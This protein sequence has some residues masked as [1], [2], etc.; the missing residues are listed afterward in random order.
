MRK[1]KK[2]I[3]IATITCVGLPFVLFIPGVRWSE[4]MG[5][6]P[7]GGPQYVAQVGDVPISAQDFLERYNDYLDARARAGGG[8][9]PSPQELM[10]DGTVERL[11]QQMV[12][13]ALLRRKMGE[14]GYDA[15]Q[16]YLAELL[17]KEV[18]FLD[19]NGQLDAMYYNQWVQSAQGIDWN[20]VYDQMRNKMNHRMVIKLTSASA[21]ALD[22]DVRRQYVDA[23][24]KIVVKHAAI[25][26]KV[27]LTE[28]EI[29]EFWE[30]SKESYLTD[31]E[32]T[33]EFVAFSLEAP[34]PPVVEDILMRAGAGEDFAELAKTF[35]Q[36]PDKSQVGDMRW[37]VDGENTPAHRKALFD[38]EAGAISDPVKGP[39]GIH[40]YK[41]E[42]KRDNE[43]VEG[44]QDVCVR[45]IVIRLALDA[46]ER[47]ARMANAKK[48]LELAQGDGGLAGAAEEKGL[49]V[50]TTDS[51][52]VGS[53][54]IK[55]VFAQDA[56]TFRQ[57]LAKVEL[58]ALSGVVE[59]SEFLY[60]A[61]VVGYIEPQQKA[62]EDVRDD[63]ERDAIALRKNGEEYLGALQQYFVDIQSKADNLEEANR[64]FPELE[65][66][67]KQ[68]KAF[69][70][71]DY[72]FTDGIFWNCQDAFNAVGRSQPGTMGG[73]IRDFSNVYHFVE[74]VEAILPTE[75]EGAK[76]WE[77]EKETL[78]ERELATLQFER[79]ADY[80][81]YMREQA[82]SEFLIQKNWE[83]ISALL[84]PEQPTE[85]VDEPVAGLIEEAAEEP[86]EAPTE[87][88]VEESLEESAE[89]EEWE[90]S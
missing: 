1:H 51:F 40:I 48:F 67:V 32:R 49:E 9:P 73:P 22:A 45:E 72:L 5:G 70:P 23:N 20:E 28:E 8:V 55:N 62:L 63:V 31:E 90:V 89:K 59:A 54:E 38:M 61:K 27:E 75:E 85:S 24:T 15:P 35:S 79:Q 17:R 78:K 87:E 6:A 2:G 65:M 46:G 25:E 26:L 16:D 86:A 71:K 14:R 41:I 74:L 47:E 33:A 69:L 36:A 64:L 80:F 77:T 57:Q 82:D 7:A 81:Q 50:Q 37:L 88:P 30:E 13:Q 34:E 29:L 19:E 42:E 18:L 53:A 4:I 43:N 11:L 58:G 21:R 76:A 66:E 10:Q 39:G 3:L 44:Q 12:D 60:V 83:A 68:T 52:S 56:S 84:I